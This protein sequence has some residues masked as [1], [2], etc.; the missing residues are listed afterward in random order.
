MKL[1]DFDFELPE[2][3]IA[4]YPE[5]QRDQSRLLHVRKKE[6]DFKEYKFSDIENLLNEG[7]CLVLN[8]SP[9]FPARIYGFSKRREVE[10]EFVLVEYAGDKRWKVLIN[11]SRRCK[12]GDIFSF[13]NIVEAEILEKEDNGV[14]LIEFNQEL[15]LETLYN[16]GQMALP[17][18]IL[19]LRE[20][21]ESDKKTYQTVY[22]KKMNEKSI[23]IN[24]SVAAPTAGLHFTEDLL[25][26]LK[27]KGLF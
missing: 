20:H 4:K 13:A 7:D 6:K 14:H 17:P 22:H 26:K 10:H 15:T 16:I 23:P 24:G 21:L 1:E 11:K 5:D 27:K 2:R 9:V 12:I 19:K 3:L 18:Y 8:E 25:N